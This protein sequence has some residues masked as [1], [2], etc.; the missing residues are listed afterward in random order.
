[1]QARDGI[2]FEEVRDAVERLYGKEIMHVSRGDRLERALE[3]AGSVKHNLAPKLRASDARQLVKVHSMKNFVEILEVLLMVLSHR[4][5]SR[6]NVLREDFPYIDN[7][8][9]LK[10]TVVRKSKAGE[11]EIWD[12][13]VP[14]TEE[15]DHVERKQIRHPFFME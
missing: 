10:Y 13:P 5:E 14:N 9:W 11:I 2:S 6:G 15:Y 1:M 7:K 12:E 3:V 8:N 4:T